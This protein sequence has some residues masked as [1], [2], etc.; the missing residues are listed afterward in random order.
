MGVVEESKLRV[1]FECATDFLEAKRMK[2]VVVIEKRNDRT[3]CDPDAV[4]DH[5]PRALLPG[6]DP[7]SLTTPNFALEVVVV[8]IRDND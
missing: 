6:E 7:L 2:E 5:R 8:E 3:L 1:L 4:G